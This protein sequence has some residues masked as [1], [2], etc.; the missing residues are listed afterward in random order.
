MKKFL[1]IIDKK[2]EFLKRNSR[3]VK[4]QF[5]FPLKVLEIIADFFFVF[6]SFNCESQR[7]TQ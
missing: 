2:Y 7:S 3:I 6:K 1:K 4:E 5:L